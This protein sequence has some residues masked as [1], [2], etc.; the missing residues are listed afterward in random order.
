M[1]PT[2]SAPKTHG[3]FATWGRAALLGAASLTWGGA[4]GAA[5]LPALIRDA[6]TADP[7]VLEARANEEVASAKLEAS[8]AQHLPVLGLQASGNVYSAK[9]SGT[10]FRGA[11]GRINLY[12]AGAIDAT[13]ERDAHRYEQ[14]QF[15][16]AETREAIAASV[17]Q[18][19]LEA[20]RAREVIEAE[21]LNLARHE[22]I[23]GDLK[24]IVANDIGRRYELV[25]AESRALQV[26]MRIVQNE[27]IMRLALS[28]LTRYSRQEATLANPVPEDWERYL[29]A[30]GVQRTHPGVEAQR[31]EAQAVRADRQALARARWPRIDLE[32]GVGNRSYTRVVANWE[33]FNRQ[34]EYTVLSAAKQI[35]AAEQRAELF[36]REI[37]QRSATAEA[38]M[39]QSLLQIRA[40]EEQIGASARVVELYEMQFKVGRRSLIELVNAYAELSSVEV[41]R[42]VAQND[43]RAAVLSYLSAQAV[44]AGWATARP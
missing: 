41:S 10:P 25:Q 42:I 16:I 32:A 34:A 15:K 33:A 21:R 4:G 35:S 11:V 14:Q 37:E 6:V 9:D 43:W 1:K 44:L 28:R 12:A 27:K 22:K 26:R 23:V 18:I 17:S 8:K 5:E 31:R 19:Y 38:D 3:L 7:A 39:A 40:A 2:T 24:I 29:P 20:L 13:I 30:E 36:E